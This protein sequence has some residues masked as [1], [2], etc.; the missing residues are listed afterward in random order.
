MFFEKKEKKRNLTINITPLI[1]VIF[2]LLIFF[3]VSSTF[4]EQPGIEL[5]LPK[6]KTSSIKRAEETIITIDKDGSIYF[7]A[8]KI[9]STQLYNKLAELQ[10]KKN[11]KQLVMQADENVAYKTVVFVMDTARELGFTDILA[12]TTKVEKNSE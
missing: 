11:K 10:L 6:A 8:D 12:L 5:S 9:K 1:D 7:N 3:M 4:V 2:L